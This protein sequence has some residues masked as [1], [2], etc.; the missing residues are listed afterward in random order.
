MNKGNGRGF[1]FYIVL[2]AI[3]AL[4]IL[5]W[6]GMW[7]DSEDYITNSEFE[8]YLKNG[9]ITDVVIQPNAEIPTGVLRIT[10][11]KSVV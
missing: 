8:S 1:G 7:E 6:K 4:S 3:F 9:D 10:D 5:L 11:R 2:L